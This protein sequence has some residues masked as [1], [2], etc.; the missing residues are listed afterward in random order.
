MS[1]PGIRNSFFLTGIKF[2]LFLLELLFLLLPFHINQT[3]TARSPLRPP[4]S[5]TFFFFFFHILLLLLLPLLPHSFLL[6]KQFY[7][8][9]CDPLQRLTFPP[10]SSKAPAQLL[11]SLLSLASPDQPVLSFLSPPSHSIS[12]QNNPATI[13]Q[14]A[15]LPTCLPTCTSILFFKHASILLQTRFKHASIPLQSASICFN[16]LQHAPRRKPISAFPPA[17][18]C[19]S[20]LPPLSR[21][22]TPQ[23]L[24][25]MTSFH[26]S[27]M[28]TASEKRAIFFFTGK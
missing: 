8:V 13:S 17:R 3:R 7:S 27:Y 26:S 22:R 12:A 5:S 4:S 20:A 15:L 10:P 1:W 19:P 21:I 18:L 24:A 25:V 23:V 9:V 2:L 16:L 14:R 28:G 6:A 11:S